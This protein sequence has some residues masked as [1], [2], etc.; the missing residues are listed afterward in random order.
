MNTKF[1]GP[2]GWA[3]LGAI[4]F[5]YPKKINL[6]LKK[7][8]EF[9]R[10]YKRLFEDL[11]FTLPCK[12]CRR[13]FKR[14][15]KQLPIDDY[16]DSRESLTYW[17]YLIHDKVN[18]KLIKQEHKALAERIEDISRKYQSG[19]L[20]TNQYKYQIQKAKKQCIYTIPSPPYEEYCK[21]FES[22]RAKCAKKR[23]EVP[24]CRMPVFKS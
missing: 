19:N 1:W 9:K 3:F 16:L 22:K 13:S 24:S 15:L 18:Q 10:Y 7:H 6:K 12:Y 2:P 23:G 14:F 4:V 17:L 20:T 21:F 11:Q 8:R 5:N